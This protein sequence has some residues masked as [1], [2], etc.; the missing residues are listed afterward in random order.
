M[1]IYH[2]LSITIALFIDKV[3]GDPPSWPH[4]VKWFG[5]LIAK[6]DKQWNNGSG[7][8]WKG[9]WMLG[10]VL[11]AAFITTWLIC[12]GAYELH[13]LVGI[14][15][16]SILI[17]STI[18]QRSLKEAALEVYQPLKSGNLIEARQKAF[19]YCR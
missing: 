3:L 17:A 12:W 6:L 9:I 16:E 14:A 11:G 10:I 19:L 13:P 7:R 1:I 4:P 2:L 5:A 15:V 8:K 18:A